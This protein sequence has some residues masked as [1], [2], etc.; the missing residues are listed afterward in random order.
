MCCALTT[1]VEVIDSAY[2]YGASGG[3]SAR[4]A[5]MR[6]RSSVMWTILISVTPATNGVSV[7]TG[8]LGVTPLD[9]TE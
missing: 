4:N 3:W 6:A 1:V 9:A 8:A 5:L 7:N 2:G